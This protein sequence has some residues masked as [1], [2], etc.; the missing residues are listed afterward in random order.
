[1][2]EPAWAPTRPALNLGTQTLTLGLL[3]IKLKELH[4]SQGPHMGYVRNTLIVASIVSAAAVANASMPS[5]RVTP[6]PLPI[7]AG[8]NQGYGNLNQGYGI[9]SSGQVT[10]S[11]LIGSSCMPGQNFCYVGDPFVYDPATGVVTDLGTIGNANGVGYAINDSGVVV[12]SIQTGRPG[13]R[14]LHREQRRQRGPDGVGSGKGGQHH[15]A[16]ATATVPGGSR[17]QRERDR[18]RPLHLHVPER[19]DRCVHDRDWARDQ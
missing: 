13:R 17:Q 5:Y 7:Q 9:N 14:P 19:A 10:G 1:M 15:A 8:Q 3:V 18:W 6:L 16:A 2:S 12:G 11:M 4:R